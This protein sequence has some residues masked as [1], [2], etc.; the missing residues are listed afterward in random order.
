MWAGL[1]NSFYWID[2]STGIGGVYLTQIL[3]FADKKSLPLY[4][5]FE[6][7]FYA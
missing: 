4:Y 5:D 7:A 6:S 2:S 1:A 3:P